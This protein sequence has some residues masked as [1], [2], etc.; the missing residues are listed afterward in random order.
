MLWLYGAVVPYVD[1]KLPGAL[2]L[3]VHF[4]RSPTGGLRFVPQA[5]QGDLA[6]CEFYSIGNMIG[7]RKMRSLHFCFCIFGF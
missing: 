2:V 5:Q 3:E 4:R 1:E 7:I 6:F